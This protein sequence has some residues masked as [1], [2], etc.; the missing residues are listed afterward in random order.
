M[1]KVVE[2]FIKYVKMDTQ[3]DDSSDSFPSTKKQFELAE[4]LKKEMEELG[5]TEIELDENC[6]LMA[7]LPANTD[8]DV[9]VIGLIAHMDTSQDMSGTNVNP[10]FIENYNGK[11]IILNR[12]KNIIMS[13]EEFPDLLKYVG[14]TLITTDGTTLLGADDKAGIAEILTAV[15]YLI[16][17]P[18]TNLFCIL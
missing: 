8:E 2:R 5:L 13:V 4:V 18:E 16:N 17:H 7:T 1:H 9:A 10:Q 15:E 6:Y 3:S 14:K 11:D 12:D